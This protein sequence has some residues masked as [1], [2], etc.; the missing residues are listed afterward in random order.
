MAIAKALKAFGQV[1]P[2]S[3]DCFALG[4]ALG[5]ERYQ[6]S[7][8]ELA[9]SAAALC[10]R[11]QQVLLDAAGVCAFFAANTVMVDATGHKGGDSKVQML[12]RIANLKAR[13]NRFC[14][15]CSGTQG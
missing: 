13:V 14:C 3:E 8:E 10:S 15:C 9:A 1:S 12:T 7:S 5:S 11:G 2:Y 6:D 4:R